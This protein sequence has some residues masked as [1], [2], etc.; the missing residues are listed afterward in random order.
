ITEHWS[1][2]C[3]DWT[4]KPCKIFPKS[5]A[6]VDESR[7]QVLAQMEGFTLEGRKIGTLFISEDVS[8]ELRSTI[9][10]TACL[11]WKLKQDI[12]DRKLV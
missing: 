9:I 3:I 12:S 11:I 4:W 6:L 8:N 5:L 2:I 1:K 10:T 7:G